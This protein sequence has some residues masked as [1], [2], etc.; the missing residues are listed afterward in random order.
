M[1][2]TALCKCPTTP[3]LK[4]YI[5]CRGRPT[6][7]TLLPV[8]QPRPTAPPTDT[9]PLYSPRALHPLPPPTPASTRTSPPGSPRSNHPGP[10]RSIRVHP[11]P[12]SSIHSPT[13][14]THSSSL[15]LPALSSSGPIPHS[16]ET[17]E[18]HSLVI[19]RQARASQTPAAPTPP[20]HTSSCSPWRSQHFV[21]LPPQGPGQSC[22]GGATRL[23]MTSPTSSPQPVTPTRHPRPVQRVSPSPSVQPLPPCTPGSTRYW[24]QVAAFPA[25]PCPLAPDRPFFAP[26]VPP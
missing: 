6:S 7:S 21:L 3:S 9:H 14:L 8:R 25:P 2:L 5:H 19:P 10:V 26:A 20:G 16:G 18:I 24:P 17:L 4:P 13:S 23:F 22:P 12:L 15:S 11:H 1:P